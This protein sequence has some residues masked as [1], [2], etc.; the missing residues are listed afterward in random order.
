MK[1]FA[2]T[3][4]AGLFLA[5]ALT[6]AAQEAP[7][8]AE[9][10]KLIEKQNQMIEQLSTRIKDLEGKTT[11]T[12][13]L[14]KVL[15]ETND[16]LAET[17]KK[18]DKADSKLILGSGIDGVKINGDL[19]AR[20]E[21]RNRNIQNQAN[22]S[23]G[24][25]SRMR[26]R[27]RLGGVWT[28][29]AES[30]EVGVGLASGN[31]TAGRSTNQDWGV[32]AAGN[33]FDHTNVFFD[34]Y[35]AKNT[36]MLDKTPLSLT[37][38]QQKSSFVN[39]IM[40]W[41]SDLRPLGFTLQ[42]GDPFGKEYSGP[43]ATAG[44]YMI[45]YLSGGGT[46]VGNA[47]DPNYI[48]KVDDNVW[49][50]AL[51]AGYA[52]KGDNVSWLA[53]GGFQYINNAYRNLGATI[54]PNS[55]NPNNAV[56]KADTGYQYQ[57]ADLYGEVKTTA[58]GIDLKPYAHAAYNLGARGDKTQAL[59]QAGLAGKMSP[60][61][62]NLAWMIGVDGK[63]GKWNLGY[64]YAYIGADAVFGPLRDS[65]FGETAGLQDTDIQGHI[66]RLSYDVK[67][68][69]NVGAT[70]FIL[71]RINGGDAV[72]RDGQADSTNLVQVD[73]VYKF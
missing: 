36:M 22:G 47:S 73:A 38:G 1:R 55:A 18:V 32:S 9:L 68:N 63:R 67:K 57:I 34:Y 8:P 46:N 24:D 58:M 30:W 2:I 7:S 53:A 17:N 21:E 14:K 16:A 59:S 56:G 3:A 51:Q 12:A 31:D 28:N 44:L 72:A 29:K 35:Y 66:I 4:S 26:G 39:T 69:L 45:R 64:G 40:N 60:N 11:D 20:Y 50:T 42:Y 13:A 33:P 41:D 10:V 52:Q 61:Q 49:Q 19:R 27:L 48:Q 70:L 5:G 65:D 25:R 37:I 43:F 54:G 23:D 62:E 6:A 71:Q 15:L